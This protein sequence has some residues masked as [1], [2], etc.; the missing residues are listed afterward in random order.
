MRVRAVRVGGGGRDGRDRGQG[1]RDG[2]GRDPCAKPYGVAF[3]VCGE[4][5]INVWTGYALR[6]FI[7]ISSGDFP[8]RFNCT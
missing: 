8:L 6:F 2:R 1:D 3:R 4:N 5:H 7:N